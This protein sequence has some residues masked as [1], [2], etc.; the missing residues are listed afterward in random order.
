METTFQVKRRNGKGQGLVAT[1]SIPR[2]LQIISET[3]HLW[4]P[5]DLPLSEAS[6]LL[7]IGSGPDSIVHDSAYIAAALPS[8]IKQQWHETIPQ[9]DGHSNLHKNS[10]HWPDQTPEQYASAHILP[11]ITAKGYLM[12]VSFL[13]NICLI[14]HACFPNA[15]FSWDQ[16]LQK[17]TI[18]VIRDIQPGDEITINYGVDTLQSRSEQIR[19][20]FGF[21]CLCNTCEKEDLLALPVSQEIRG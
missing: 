1:T 17:G 13:T 21:I 4:F 9:S 3:P 11:A 2:G 7:G 8:P 5:I 18:H 6:R 10:G 19:E 20:R 14:N 12:R 16:K 15:E